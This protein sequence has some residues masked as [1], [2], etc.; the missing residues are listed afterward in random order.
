MGPLDWLELA[1][2]LD[3]VAK[4]LRVI[5]ALEK[6]FYEVELWLKELDYRLRHTQEDTEHEN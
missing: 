2:Q 1:E 5:R 6:E 3:R 4:L